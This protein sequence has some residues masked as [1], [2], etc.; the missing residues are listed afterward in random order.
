MTQ[1]III[2]GLIVNAII[3]QVI[4]ISVK[5]RQIS[6]SSVFWLSFLFSPIVGMFAAIMSPQIKNDGVQDI[7]DGKL[8]LP[9]KTYE[10]SYVPFIEKNIAPIIA[11][12]MIVSF[13]VGFW[14]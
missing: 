2:I 6:S 8:N 7:D 1:N 5:N 11:V 14:K 12:V 4:A 10:D 9:K 3:S 13:V